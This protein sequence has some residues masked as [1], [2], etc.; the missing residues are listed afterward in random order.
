MIR[1]LLCVCLLGAAPAFASDIKLLAE[2]D[3]W[4]ILTVPVQGGCVASRAFADGTTLRIRFDP[5]SGTGILHAVQPAWGPLI[6]GDAYAF[7]YD[8]DGSV[9]EAEGMGHYFGGQPGVALALPSADLLTALAST[10]TLRIYFG[11]A[12]VMALDLTGSAQALQATKDCRPV[13]G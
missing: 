2:L 6:E 7:A 10:E 13:Q 12:E 3:G 9:A 5:A 8:L 4:R 11:E 1:A